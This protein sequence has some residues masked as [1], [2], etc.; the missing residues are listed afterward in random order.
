MGRYSSSQGL[1]KE[2]TEGSGVHL[3]LRDEFHAK[4][5][6]RIP[7]EEILLTTSLDSSANTTELAPSCLGFMTSLT[8][9]FQSS[10]RA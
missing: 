7:G 10:I 2:V 3:S 4:E 5:K 1:I 6:K 9:L 8:T